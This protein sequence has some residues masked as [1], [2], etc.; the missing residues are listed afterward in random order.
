VEVDAIL[1]LR[2]WI[3]EIVCEAGDSG[4]FDTCR[5]VEVGISGAA[6]DAAVPD[7]YVG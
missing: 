1:I 2:G 4:K 6:V 3:L 7:A 5:R